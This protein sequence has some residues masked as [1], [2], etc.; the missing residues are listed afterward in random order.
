MSLYKDKNSNVKQKTF[1]STLW[2]KEED[3]LLI[4]K[5][6]EYNSNNWK[7][8]SLFFKN[9]TSKQCF[10]RFKCLDPNIKKGRWTEK[11]DSLLLTLIDVYGRNW[12]EISK[13]L[14]HR[15]GKQIRDRYL[16]ILDPSLNKGF[17]TESEDKL[18][19]ILYKLH[20]K[21][22]KEIAMHFQGRTGEMI[23]NRFY[24]YISKKLLVNEEPNE[25]KMN[26]NKYENIDFCNQ[27]IDKVVSKLENNENQN[28]NNLDILNNLMEF[29]K[30]KRKF[31]RSIK[32]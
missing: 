14:K 4:L 18:L 8:I 29:T 7:E 3:E 19:L 10:S 6:N 9:K 32:E 21:S 2:S 30:L 26:C 11:E 22:W 27:E 12:N 5:V 28:R 17:F 23:K 31:Y 13:K 25:C 16:N 1:K 24:S 20:G 15:T